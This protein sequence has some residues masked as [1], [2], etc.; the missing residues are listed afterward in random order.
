MSLLSKEVIYKVR[1][2]LIIKRILDFIISLFLLILLSP[3]F[4]IVSIAIKLDSSGPVLYKQVRTGF[5]GADFTLLK[6]RSMAEDNDVY[7]FK[8][9]DRITKVGQF[10]RKTSLD[11]LPQLVNILLEICHLWDQD[12]GYLFSMIIIQRIKKEDFW[13][14]QE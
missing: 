5:N 2:Y 14:D 13:L 1:F 10:I 8:T 3:L 7:D 6:F 9:G 11:E 12:L 4:L